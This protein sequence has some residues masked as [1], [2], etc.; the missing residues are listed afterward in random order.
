MKVWSYLGLGASILHNVLVKPHSLRELTGTSS[1]SRIIRTLLNSNTH[2]P[3]LDEIPD[4]FD[5]TDDVYVLPSTAEDSI[6][7]DIEES[8]DLSSRHERRD[9]S[10]NLK[11]SIQ[12]ITGVHGFPIFAVPILA[13]QLRNI[14]DGAE[15]DVS[16]HDN[17]EKA[18]SYFYY[19]QSH[20]WTFAVALLNHTLQY[21]NLLHVVQRFLELV[22]TEPAER[23]TMTRVGVLTLDQNPVGDIAFFPTKI[24]PN[25]TLDNLPVPVD[26]NISQPINVTTIT[27]NGPTPGA[28]IDESRALAT[29]QK[30]FNPDLPKRDD[31]PIDNHIL[32]AVADTACNMALRIWRNPNRMFSITVVSAALLYSALMLAVT[33]FWFGVINTGFYNMDIGTGR[34]VDVRVA[35]D[36]LAA[37]HSDTSSLINV[38]W[39]SMLYLSG[40]P[41]SIDSSS[42]RLGSAF[43]RFAMWVTAVD[44]EG[45]FVVLKPEMWIR[46]TNTL[47]DGLKRQ[48]LYSFSY[49]LYGSFFG[50][51]VYNGTGE[52]VK[53]GMW[54]LVAV[55]AEGGG[56]DEL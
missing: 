43:A 26:K 17:S 42:Y 5:A 23:Y 13:S 49:A 30:L 55:P 53:L 24:T 27:R 18:T 9:T 8:N 11:T 1:A 40:M 7:Q 37:T 20:G 35:A 41:T 12:N 47:L 3:S 33:R 14:L 56:Q 34:L 36:D 48:G 25:K 28:A 50:P 15:Q 10:L 16:S 4:A 31:L 46:F 21:S 19:D 54:K 45:R 51:D 39:L 44:Q 6:L 22:P 38:T 29:V 2:V 32:I 52:Q